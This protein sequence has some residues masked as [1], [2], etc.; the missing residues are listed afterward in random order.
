VGE[1]DAE[2]DAKRRRRQQVLDMLATDGVTLSDGKAPDG[3]SV[4]DT[5]GPVKMDLKLSMGPGKAKSSLN[6][7]GQHMLY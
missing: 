3:P 2:A 7:S 5:S 4:A 6:S 1:T